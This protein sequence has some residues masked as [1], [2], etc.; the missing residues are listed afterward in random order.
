M[1]CKILK[2]TKL[3][4]S[5]MKTI[6]AGSRT[7]TNML[8]VELACGESEFFITE[9]VCGGA[10][11][12]DQLGNDWARAR[13]IPVKHFPADWRTHGKSAGPIRNRQMAEYA[14]ALI[15]VHD[16]KSRGTK[17]MI[18]EATKRGLKVFVKIFL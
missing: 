6:I 17:N 1:N 2:P 18:E 15:A 8:E 10:A 3:T 5:T 11:G 13:K 14:E 7:I 4:A 9:V 16:G 12:V